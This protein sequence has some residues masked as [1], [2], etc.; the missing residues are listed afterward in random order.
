MCCRRNGADH[1]YDIVH[2]LNELPE[3]VRRTTSSSSL[4]SSW[5]FPSDAQDTFDLSSD[6]ELAEY[7]RN[8]RQSWVD[9]L[10]EARLREREREDE[11]EQTKRDETAKEVENEQVRK[12]VHCC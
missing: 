12:V 6:E 8:R 2:L 5:S 9:G 7:A 4:S 10:R 1:R 3:S 11:E